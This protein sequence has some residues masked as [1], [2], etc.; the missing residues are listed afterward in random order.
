MTRRQGQASLTTATSQ[1]SLVHQVDF[2]GASG[3]TNYSPMTSGN[4]GYALHI[5]GGFDPV[6][7]LSSAKTSNI[8]ETA[9]ALLLRANGPH[10]IW[11]DVVVTATYLMNQIPSK[12]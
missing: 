1:L 3:L 6:V 5:Y 10:F 7:G 9:R 8:L 11:D 12:Y 4:Y 2:F